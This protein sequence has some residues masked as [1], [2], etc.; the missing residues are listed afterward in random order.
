MAPQFSIGHYRITSKLGEGGMGTVYRAEDTRLNRSVAIKILPDTFAQD[1]DRLTRFAREAQVLASLNHPNIAAIYGVEERALVM[2]LVEGDTLAE[3]I[4]R[5]PVPEEEA[6]PIVDQLIDAL[7]YA[8]QK[9]IVHRDLKPANI[10]L[11]PDGRV[12]VLDFGLAKAMA[13][14]VVASDPASSPTLTMRAT[15]AG[16]ILGTA[17]YMSPE[18]ARGHAV[19]ERADIWAF[20][21]VVY[22]LLTG[23]RLFEGPTVSDALASVLKE[24]PNLEAVPE[25]MRGMLRYCLEKDP[26]KRLRHIADARILLNEEKPGAATP[27]PEA[28]RRPV[29][30]WSLLA[31]FAITALSLGIALWRASRPLEQPPMW[32]SV[33]LGQEASQGRDTTAAISPDGSHIVF[34]VSS[35][36]V[37]RLAVRYLAQPNA[38]PLPG[39]ETAENPFFSPDGEWVAFATREGKI[40]KVSIHG[41]S[42]ITLC[43]GGLRGGSWGED[44]YIVAALGTGTGLSR[45][46][47]GGGPPQPLTTLENGEVTHR[48]PQVLPGGQAVLFSANTNYIGWDQASVQVVWVKTGRKKVIQQGASF[49]RY[50]PNGYLAYVHGSSLYGMPFDIDRMQPKGPPAT[51]LEDVAASAYGGGQLDFSRNGTLVYLAGKA[52]VQNK[53]QLVQIDAGGKPERLSA[54]VEPFS[55]LALSP[56]GKQVAVTI[57]LGGGGGGGDLYVFDLQREISTK[58]ATAGGVVLHAIW[59]PDGK[60]LVYG[61]AP[62]K[63]NN[64]MMWIR[65]DGSTEPQLLVARSLQEPVFPVCISP[66]GRR[67]YLVRPERGRLS[68]LS[69]VAIDTGDPDHPKAG[70]PEIVLNESVG[71]ASI[72]PDGRWLAYTSPKSGIPQIFVRSLGAD[73]KPRG[74]LWQISASGGG[75]PLWSRAGRQL[76]FASPDNHVMAVEYSVSGDAFQALKPQ[77]WTERPIGTTSGNGPFAHSYDLTADG[78]RIITWDPDEVRGGAK[79][80]LHITA[81]TNWFGEVERRFAHGG[82]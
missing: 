34:A 31:V 42:P 25:S 37:S 11:T 72:S 40:K 75:Q 4:A 64:G 79:A 36:G 48:W 43:D 14:E 39:T 18:Q 53:H 16:V 50:L 61:T 54:P 19:D 15:V 9:G 29:M 1:A 47:E 65:A 66:D 82:R 44:G 2:E 73:G 6:R 13:G 76:L 26:R 27:R 24:A 35:G 28:P 60:H 80:N 68:G 62:A 12:K 45:I 70:E 52:A 5:G 58:L 56:D 41:G 20:G 3:R 59:A 17:G 51:L 57:G 23:G 74:G 10:K 55:S 21:V 49:G 38:T 71:G 81:R 22:E 8:H 30:L 7:E 32:L 78:K 67:I 63:N 46:P 33:D 69:S 77:L